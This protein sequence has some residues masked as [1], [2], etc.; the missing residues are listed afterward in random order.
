MMKKTIFAALKIIGET[1]LVIPLKKKLQAFFI[2][3]QLVVEKNQI[4]F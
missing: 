1:H 2:F 3:K 4:F